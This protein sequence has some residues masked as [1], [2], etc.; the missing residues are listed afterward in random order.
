MVQHLVETRAV[1][2]GNA[3]L[4]QINKDLLINVNKMS[5]YFIH[6]LNK[7]KIKYLK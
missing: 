1:A 2:V 4:D 6:E 3:V 5:K 7:I